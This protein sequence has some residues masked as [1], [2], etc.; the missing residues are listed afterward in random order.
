MLFNKTNLTRGSKF[1]GNVGKYAI[2]HPSVTSSAFKLMRDQDIPSSINFVTEV[3]KNG[4]TANQATKTPT[5][6]VQQQ[7]NNNLDWNTLYSQVY[8]N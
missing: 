4:L 3:V 5:F 1:L 2:E 6:P 8:P 7:T